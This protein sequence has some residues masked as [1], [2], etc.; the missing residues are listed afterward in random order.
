MS[1]RDWF[2]G[3]ALAGQIASPNWPPCP[4]PAGEEESAA[5]W[6]YSFADAMLAARETTNPIYLNREADTPEPEL[7]DEIEELEVVAFRQFVGGHWY[8]EVGHTSDPRAEHLVRAYDATTLLAEKDMEIERLREHLDRWLESA[9]SGW[10]EVHRLRARITELEARE[11]TAGM[12]EAASR[13]Y[14][15]DAPGDADYWEWQADR[16]NA[17]L[18]SDSE[19]ATNDR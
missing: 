5:H 10:K 15:T 18:R 12:I 11:V 2:A 6:A 1:L 19:E 9:E 4:L 13:S 16:I 7:V 17:A 3:Q 14:L 8:Y